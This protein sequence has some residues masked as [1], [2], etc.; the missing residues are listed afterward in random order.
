M[1]Q[2][3]RVFYREWALF[4][5]NQAAYWFALLEPALYLLFFL[6]G[7]SH[8]THGNEHYAAFALPGVLA[9]LA[10]TVSQHTGAPVFFDRFTGEAETLRTLPISQAA[11]LSGRL[12]IALCRMLIQS[13]ISLGL[14]KLIYPQVM[15]LHAAALFELW[16]ASGAAAVVLSSLSISV[17]A[18]V[19]NNSQLN[20]AFSLLYTPLLLTSSAF[21]PVTVLPF[22]VRW[23][24]YVNP[25]TYLVTD[26]RACM[27]ISALS[28]LDVV[29][30][31]AATVLAL[32]II[33]VRSSTT[34]MH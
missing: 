5:A 15:S 28:W 19:K 29:I 9:I 20:I 2:I 10:M 31:V 18:S 12:I 3:I 1:P 23:V 22:W 27:A 16:C 13:A 30:P 32:A 6:P 4:R 21:Y 11:M 7:I 8:L 34:T 26:M 25:L 33:T 24:A 17:A 14:A